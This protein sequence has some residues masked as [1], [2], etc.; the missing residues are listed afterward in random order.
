MRRGSLAG[1]RRMLHLVGYR[2]WWYWSG[3]IGWTSFFVWPLLPGWL[4]AKV[5]DE[6]QSDG[7][8]SRFW[9]LVVATLLAEIAGAMFVYLAHRLYVPG[10]E[11][12]KN[13]LR[14]NALNGQLAS[15]GTEQAA[16]D[17]PVGDA[18]ARLRDDP[19]DTVFLLDNWTDLV[20]SMLYAAGAAFL[21]VRI[22]PL[23]AA[24][25]MVPMVFVGVA[26]SKIG[27]LARR[28][29]ERSRRA[30][31][32]A[33][34]F[35]NAVF[36]ATLTVK[37][38]GAQQSVLRRLDTLNG[39]RA[40]SMVRDQVWNDLI[41]SINSTFA[42]VFVGLALVVAARGRL[43]AGEVTQF[44]NYL[45]TLAWLPMRLGGT[46]VGRRRYDVSARRLDALVAPQRSPEDT[47]RLVEHRP[48]P[49]LGGPPA[50][51]PVRP[52]RVPLETLEVSGLTVTGRG[53]VDVSFTVGK[54]QLVVV[55]GPVGAGKTTLL[56]AVVGLQS[57]DAG[58]VRWNG[59]V[60]ADRAA[61]FVPPQCAYV[62]QV[63]R[64]FSETLE[65]NLRL[66][67]DLSAEE[68][69]AGVRMAAFDEDVAGFPDGLR[70]LVGAR[71]VRLS[72]GQAQRAAAAR[73]MA[74]RPELLVLDDLT[75]ALDVETE[76]ALWDRL[77]AAGLTVLA[78][79]NRPAALDR[80]DAVVELR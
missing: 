62:A 58:E 44:A 65:D 71:G 33:G 14:V 3:A 67:H 13:L 51:R 40:H 54:G 1:E 22:D 76:I 52:R 34:N 72:G 38:T 32:E 80:A 29:R 46:V 19:F 41:W 70:T 16:R 36:E 23:A 31:S 27:T 7:A 39:A 28:Y 8:S 43:S 5:F 35:L 11:A 15:G 21:L 57:I 48:L 42:D 30:A 64:L 26:N 55:S 6:L 66:G 68:V 24:V 61:F 56:R 10:V 78:A 77:A 12:A 2:G 9:R 53:V 47:D 50:A 75:S 60:V 4:I 18:I 73:A 79:S 25:G 17:V 74:H 59:R 63:P 20:G 45:L 37:V 49:I 69:L